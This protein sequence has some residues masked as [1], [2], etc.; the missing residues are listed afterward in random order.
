MKTKCKIG[1][2]S[3]TPV[4]CNYHPIWGES[5]ASLCA[6]YPNPPTYTCSLWELLEGRRGLLKGEK[7]PNASSTWIFHP[8]VLFQPPHVVPLSLS[9]THLHPVY[10]WCPRLS[11]IN[12]RPYEWIMISAEKP[13]RPAVNRLSFRRTFMPDEQ[14][15]NRGSRK[16]RA[17]WDC[18]DSL[19][20]PIKIQ[21]FLPNSLITCWVTHWRKRLRVRFTICYIKTQ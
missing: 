11:E 5:L 1:R 18:H 2:T 7:I 13:I 16:V 17:S 15:S 12:L 9:L 3:I 10:A 4:R 19:K 14:Q 21:M 8:F 6:Q 20:Q